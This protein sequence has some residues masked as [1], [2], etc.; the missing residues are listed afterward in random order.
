VVL[1]G[2]S[3]ERLRQDQL[4][5][6]RLGR[7]GPQS[8][9]IMIGQLSQGG[10]ERQLYM[11]LKECDR[12]LWNPV[13]YVSGELGYWEEP[14]RDL[15]IPV[16]LLKG[17]RLAK[18][19]QF[20]S[21]CIA[22]SAKYFFSWSSYTNGYALALAGC[23]V[24][25]IGSF[26]N[27]AFA[28]LP[29]RM[30]LFWTW[31]SVAGLTRAV[32]NSHETW[33]QLNRLRRL[34]ERVVHV[35]NA[36]Q[37]FTPGQI[38]AWREKWRRHLG[39]TDD[40]VLILGV[41]RIT[42]QKN[43]SRFI[44]VVAEVHGMLPVQAVIAGRDHGTMPELQQKIDALGLHDT[45][46]FIGTVP[47][48]RELMCAADIFLLTSDYEGMPNVVMEAMAVGVPCVVT[49]VNGVQDVIQNGVSGFICAPDAQELARR[50][51]SLV[52]NPSLRCGIGDKA[53]NSIQN[54]HSPEQVSHRL[55]SLCGQEYLS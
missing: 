23:G 34:K 5:Q 19:M 50:V 47:D 28:D 1:G 53:K 17:N 49:K 42:S 40:Q 8:I 25:C 54:N 33:A 15:R 24:H 18:M 14:I 55:W 52:Q 7:A 21:A 27:A 30:R 22:Q 12:S 41:G 31:F 51:L 10:S 32:C 4:L 29:D 3:Q 26:R 36:V 43:F 39:L 46:R 9:A 37:V 38:A 35:P 16:V 48:A 45:V 13:V 20:R 2:Q 11:F 6:E 44:D